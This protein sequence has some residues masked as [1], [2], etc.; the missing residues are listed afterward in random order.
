MET[1]V[2]RR[3]G[4]PSIHPSSIG[5]PLHLIDL[6][7][8]AKTSPVAFEIDGRRYFSTY[9]CNLAHIAKSISAMLSNAL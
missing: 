1:N 8:L 5:K 4:E 6:D 3:H 2:V 7:H 9:H